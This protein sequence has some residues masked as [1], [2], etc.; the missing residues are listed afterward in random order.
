MALPLHTSSV[1]PPEAGNRAYFYKFRLASC[2][3]T[4]HIHQTGG[5]TVFGVADLA[6]VFQ[7]DVT[8][9]VDIFQN[10]EAAAEIYFA[11]AHRTRY[12]RIV[13]KKEV[14]YMHHGNIVSYVADPVQ[15]QFTAMAP[16]IA[17]IGI[18][19]QV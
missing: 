11:F 15:R 10:P 7:R 3:K 19:T 13:D 16:V 5:N 14:L 2:L 9:V 1:L 12:D 8:I 4:P 18:G 6:F 17:D